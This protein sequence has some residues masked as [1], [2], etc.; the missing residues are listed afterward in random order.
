MGVGG[1]FEPPPP[2]PPPRSASGHRFKSSASCTESCPGVVNNL[3]FPTSR[4]CG[5]KS[6]INFKES[7]YGNYSVSKIVRLVYQ[8][9]V[10]TPE[11]LLFLRNC[12]G[13]LLNIV[14][15]LLLPHKLLHTGFSRYFT[16]YLSSSS[17]S[18]NTRHSHSG[19]NFL[20]L[21]FVKQFGYSFAFDAPTV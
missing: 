1:G 17:S 4:G 21:I 6:C 11:K 7:I 14:H 15:C 8:T 10:D 12:I 19:R 9:P 13:F 5:Y 18:Y 2:P 16:P 3:L 20:V